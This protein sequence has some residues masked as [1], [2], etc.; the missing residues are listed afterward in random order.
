[1]YQARIRR[2]LILILLRLAACSELS[3]FNAEHAEEVAEIAEEGKG[4]VL[5]AFIS[6]ASA[7]PAL[8]RCL[9]AIARLEAPFHH[10]PEIQIET[11]PGPFR[12]FDLSSFRDSLVCRPLLP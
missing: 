11:L 4:G 6:A 1:L 8:K 9:A 5:S 2:H 10:P 12:V 7:T 3:F